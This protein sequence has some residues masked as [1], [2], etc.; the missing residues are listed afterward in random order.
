[1]LAIMPILQQ[2]AHYDQRIF[3]WCADFC[4]SKNLPTYSKII[5]H[6]GDGYLQVFIPLLIFSIVGSEAL[7]FLH[8][9]IIAFSLERALYWVLKNNFK[10]KRPEAALPYFKANITA[11]DEFSFPSGHTSAAFLLA[12]LVSG[13]FPILATIMFIWASLVSASRIILGVHFPADIIAGICL[14]CISA[15]LCQWIMLSYG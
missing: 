8:L 12:I 11:S 9:V 15:Y 14:G 6:S 13:Y 7:P 3:L 5:S 4:H 2:L 10:R 1:M